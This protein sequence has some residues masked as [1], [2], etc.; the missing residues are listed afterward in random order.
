MIVRYRHGCN[1]E[2][3]HMKKIVSTTLAALATVSALSALA[4]VSTDAEAHR[5]GSRARVGVYIGGPVIAPWRPYYGYGYGYGYGYPYGYPYYTP[6]PVV[7]Q[8]QPTV[9]VEQAAA[10]AGAPVAP[11][12]SAAPQEQQQYWYYCQ[13]SKTY[14]PHAQNC[15]SPWQRVIPHAPQ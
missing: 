3:G 5:F 7:V 13:D 6:A 9:Y 1:P 10:V 15:A 8:E 2:E 4:L 12:P 11:A 14:Y